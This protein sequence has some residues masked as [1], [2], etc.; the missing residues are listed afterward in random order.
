[1]ELAS[2]PITEARTH[3]LVRASDPTAWI[4]NWRKAEQP[5]EARPLGRTPCQPEHQEI[6][7]G[8]RLQKAGEVN[9]AII[10]FQTAITELQRTPDGTTILGEAHA[11]LAVTFQESGL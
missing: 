1:M 3:L 7:N 10:A 6:A 8:R 2:L 4:N 11:G 5:S 9:K